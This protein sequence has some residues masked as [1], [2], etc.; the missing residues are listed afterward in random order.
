MEDSPDTEPKR[1]SPGRH[2]LSREEVTASQRA[3]LLAAM[4]EAAAE[5]GYAAVTVADV[6]KRAKVSR[7]TFYQHFSGK[8]ECFAAAYAA[9]TDA[10]MDVLT[11]ALEEGGGRWESIERAVGAY[12]DALAAEPVLARLFLVEAY[13]AGPEFLRRRI[14]RQ[15]SVVDALADHVGARSPQGRLTCEALL[16]AVVSMAT[17]R[18]IRDDFAALPGLRAPLGALLRGLARSLDEDPDI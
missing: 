11:G 18:I 16:G 17:A 10:L 6:L 3:R 15:R 13:A 8:E 1:L 12:L 14:D 5:K 4:A 7:L 9:A 2:G